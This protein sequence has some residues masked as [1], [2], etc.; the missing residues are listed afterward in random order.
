MGKKKLSKIIEGKVKNNE[1]DFFPSPF[2]G[3]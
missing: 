2:K 1:K 3:H